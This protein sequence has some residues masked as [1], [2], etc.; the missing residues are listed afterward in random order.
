MKIF[1]FYTFSKLF[2]LLWW[3]HVYDAICRFMALPSNVILNIPIVASIVAEAPLSAEHSQFDIGTWHTLLLNFLWSALCF[4]LIMPPREFWERDNDN[5]KFS[6]WCSN[7][8]SFRVNVCA[9]VVHSTVF[10]RMRAIVCVWVR[11]NFFSVWSVMHT[12]LYYSA[13]HCTRILKSAFL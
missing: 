9:Y 3:N 2:L 13:L 12:Y 4:I 6:K 1:F 10:N 11:V 8:T 7:I 5:R